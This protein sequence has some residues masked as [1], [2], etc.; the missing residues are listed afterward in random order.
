[1]K[2]YSL[3]FLVVINLI[4]YTWRTHLLAT[5]IYGSSTNSD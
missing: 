3:T 1:M 5:K 4:V 2:K